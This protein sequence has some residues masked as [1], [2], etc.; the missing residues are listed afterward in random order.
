MKLVDWPGF[1]NSYGM[2]WRIPG[3]HGSDRLEHQRM[4]YNAWAVG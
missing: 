4:S 1:I 3:Q 2:E